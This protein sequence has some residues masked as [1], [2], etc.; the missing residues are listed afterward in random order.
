MDEMHRT[1]LFQAALKLAGLKD[2]RYFGKSHTLDGLQNY[3]D[4]VYG[5]NY[6]NFTAGELVIPRDQ[7]ARE[8]MLLPEH[9]WWPR[10]AFLRYMADL[11]R[12]DLPVTVAWLW[13]P[14]WLNDVVDSDARNS[15]HLNCCAIDLDFK[16]P[17]EV[18]RVL[19]SVVHPMARCPVG[20][21]VAMGIGVGATRIH[22]DF[23]SSAWEEKGKK[24]RWW[25]YASA[26]DYK[27]PLRTT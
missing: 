24:L 5:G 27:G 20:P 14:P 8:E 26:P 3:L 23:F 19:E 7:R 21:G 12:K 22:L 25:A 16:T 1:S 4:E 13:R 18:A 17:A 15:A 10:I 11:C 9:L 6:S 2:A